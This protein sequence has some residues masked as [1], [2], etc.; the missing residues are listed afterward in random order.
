M[1]KGQKYH[2]RSVI[3]LL[4][5]GGCVK[6]AIHYYIHTPVFSCS[7]FLFLSCSVNLKM[8]KHTKKRDKTKMLQTKHFSGSQPENT[9]C[10]ATK[11]P[12]TVNRQLGAETKLSCQLAPNFFTLSSSFYLLVLALDFLQ[13]Q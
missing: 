12:W 1:W 8:E 4:P 2:H 5:S 11:P 13:L 3:E 9:E 7:V 10:Q 6:K